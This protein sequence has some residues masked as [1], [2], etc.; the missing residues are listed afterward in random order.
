[1]KKF[2]ALLLTAATAVFFIHTAASALTKDAD[3]CYMIG[4]AAEWKEFALKASSDERRADAKL[5]ADLDFGGERT[6]WYDEYMPASGDGNDNANHYEGNFDGC[7]HRVTFNIKTEDETAHGL[8]LFGNIGV[9]GSVRNVSVAGSVFCAGEFAGGVAAVNY[10]IIENCSNDAFV[11]VPYHSGGIVG[12]N[13]SGAVVKDCINNGGAE[14]IEH[15]GGIAGENFATITDCINT[16][17]AVG[18]EDVGGIAGESMG[19]LLYCINYGPVGGRAYS[20]GI[21]GYS[22]GAIIECGN[23][24]AVTGEKF[25][26]GI[27]GENSGLLNGCENEGEVVGGMYVGG[28]AGFCNTGS[29]LDS[30]NG[31][32][33]SGSDCVGGIAGLITFAETKVGN[34]RNTAAVTLKAGGK[35]AGGF[36]GKA[37]DELTEDGV[38]RIYRNIEIENCTSKHGARAEKDSVF[39]G[40]FAGEVSDANGGVTFRNCVWHRSLSDP[41]FS[42]GTSGGGSL[43]GRE[44]EGISFTEDMH[45]GGTGCSS[46]FAAL[47][48][49]AAAP[50]VLLFKRRIK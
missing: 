8:G 22:E 30:L 48:L 38:R 47:A 25:T 40:G 46:G 49:L 28:I 2:T 19:D 29:T 37:S 20:G 4:T 15:V 27:A 1:M 16:G 17:T 6:D 5:T 14:G 43:A 10:G 36:V 11:A 31:G 33:V 41:R 3:G 7:G 34:C 26:G 21:T 32:E 45:G 18:S 24:A 44:V 50:P 42:A 13:R 9:N 23:A 39:V 12:H 35:R